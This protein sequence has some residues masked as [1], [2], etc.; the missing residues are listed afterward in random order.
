M[1]D[2]EI[3]YGRNIL[4]NP[5][6]NDGTNLWAGVSNVS[7]VEGG[8]DDYDTT[9]NTFRFEPTASMWQK[10]G[11]PGSPPDLEFGCY[12]LPGRDIRSAAQVRA[13]IKLTLHY[14]DG[15]VGQYVVPGKT[16]IGEW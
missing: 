10:R 15:S 9:P 16:M 11:V 4:N 5:T 7:V 13:Q 14:G 1:P 12:F 3:P 2:Y 6:A 8:V